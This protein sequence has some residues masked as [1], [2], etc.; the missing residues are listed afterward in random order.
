MTCAVPADYT[1]DTRPEEIQAAGGPFRLIVCSCTFLWTP[2][3]ASCGRLVLNAFAPQVCEEVEHVERLSQKI[4]KLEESLALKTAEARPADPAPV[5]G[6]H[7]NCL[8]RAAQGSRLEERNAQLA[9]ELEQTESV[10]KSFLEQENGRRTAERTV[11]A[12]QV[13]TMRTELEVRFSFGLHGDFGLKAMCSEVNVCFSSSTL[14][15]AA[16]SAATFRTCECRY[17]NRDW[18]RSS[19]SSAFEIA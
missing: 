12:E 14:G 10:L 2:G 16:A 7:A 11:E 19:R 17:H 15:L 8:S 6:S 4:C 1:A 5:R 9:S 3:S 13:K 18:Q